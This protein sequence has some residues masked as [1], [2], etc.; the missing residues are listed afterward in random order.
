MARLK[1][2]VMDPQ[3]ISVLWG[4]LDVAIRTTIIEFT[5]PMRGEKR[6]DLL[7]LGEDLG[8]LRSATT[9]ALALDAVRA[10]YRGYMGAPGDWGYDHP[11]G[12]AL[13]GM[14]DAHRLVV[15]SRKHEPLLWALFE[16]ELAHETCP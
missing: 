8:R 4:T 3:G 10:V 6:A 14:Y 7:R 5:R 12:Q 16:A 1:E 2:G 13:K 11:R 15:A 9:P